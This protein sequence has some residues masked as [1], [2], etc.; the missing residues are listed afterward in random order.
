MAVQT[1]DRR[2]VN[3]AVP[4]LRECPARDLPGLP[5][6]GLSLLAL[7]GGARLLIGERVLASHAG[8]GPAGSAASLIGGPLIVLGRIL[9]S[10]LTTAAPR[11]ARV[12]QRLR[13]YN[14]TA[15]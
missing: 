3:L 7:L 2:T 12:V 13:R 11:H 14:G 9:V 8:H 10:G 6:L 5:L 1:K 15:R 4:Y